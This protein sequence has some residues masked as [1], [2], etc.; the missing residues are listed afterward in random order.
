[1]LNVLICIQAV[2]KNKTCTSIKI[3][4]RWYDKEI[5]WANLGRPFNLY[6]HKTSNKVFFSYTVPETYSDVDFQLAYIDL[7][8]REFQNI[9]GIRG[10]CSVAIDQANDEIYLGGSDGIYKYNMMTKLA[11]FYKEAGRNIWA[12]FF[13]RNLFYISY[14]D[15]RLHIE[16]DGKF[17]VVNEFENFEVDHFHV[18]VDHENIYF[19]NKTGFY[20]YDNDRLKVNVINDVITVRQISE[21][22]DG[23]LYICTNLGVYVDL[24]NEGFQKVLDYKNIYSLTFDKD[25]NVIVS[26]EKRIIKL[27]HTT[28]GCSDN[29]NTHW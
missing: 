19:A 12:L 16:V 1:M 15:Q 10:G 3:Q 29:V 13:R 17:A 4:D 2:Q 11:D 25:N 22:N 9:A 5:L 18:T 24:K 28:T 14:P 21:D 20:N 27:K 8:T 23:D 7:E 6:G 26:D